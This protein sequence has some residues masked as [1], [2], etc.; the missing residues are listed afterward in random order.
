MSCCGKR[1]EQFSGTMQAARPAATTA[2][3]QHS[4]RTSAA[5]FEYVGTTSMTVAGPI[6]GKRYHFDQPGA[7]VAVDPVDKPSLKAVPH[8]REIFGAG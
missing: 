4:Y 1:R 6:S 2:P 3:V 5:Y 7:K 8:L